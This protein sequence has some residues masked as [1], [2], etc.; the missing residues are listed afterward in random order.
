MVTQLG[1]PVTL[2]MP[3][4]IPEHWQPHLPPASTEWI[5]VFLS[6]RVRQTDFNQA[7]THHAIIR[8]DVL[9]IRPFYNAAY[10]KD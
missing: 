6:N 9:I 10:V 5:P 4:S 3:V 7:G 1:I 2:L 8:A